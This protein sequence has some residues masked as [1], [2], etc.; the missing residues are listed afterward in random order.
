[1]F[2]KNML[3]NLTKNQLIGLVIITVIVL[4]FVYFVYNSKNIFKNSKRVKFGGGSIMENNLSILDSINDK[5][6]QNL[7]NMNR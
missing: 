6:D 4:V 7:G 2:L 1:M 5:Q 3:L